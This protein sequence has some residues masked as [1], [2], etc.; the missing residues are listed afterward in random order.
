MITGCSPQEKTDVT[1]AVGWNRF[2][3]EAVILPLVCS[4]ALR[5]VDV[6]VRP[7]GLPDEAAVEVGEA[8]FWVGGQ[9]N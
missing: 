7:V 2:D 6:Q 9:G 4:F 8:R 1:L 5:C 3:A